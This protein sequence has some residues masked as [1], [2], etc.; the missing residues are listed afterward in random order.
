MF[1]I[2]TGFNKKGQELIEAYTLYKSG[3][4]NSYTKDA[5]KR[6]LFQEKPAKVKQ[7]VQDDVSVEEFSEIISSYKIYNKGDA[8]FSADCIK[9]LDENFAGVSFKKY[10]SGKIAIQKRVGIKFN[11]VPEIFGVTKDEAKHLFKYSDFVLIFVNTFVKKKV[12]DIIKANN[13]LLGDFVNV[14]IS[15]SY[16]VKDTNFIDIDVDFIVSPLTLEN[17]NLKNVQFICDKLS[18]ITL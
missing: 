14:K 13:D 1:K 4:L 2:E 9:Y 15:D 7:A 18:K 16:F 5:V 3:S 6:A 17:V 8:D 10:P 12:K 11:Q